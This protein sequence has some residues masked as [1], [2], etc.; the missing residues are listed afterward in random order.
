MGPLFG[1]LATTDSFPLSVL[2]TTEG[3]S[4]KNR[5]ADA[6]MLIWPYLPGETRRTGAKQ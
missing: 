6:P 3:T 4:D 1:P 2:S 5:T